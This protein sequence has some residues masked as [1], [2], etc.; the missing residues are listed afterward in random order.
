[1]K[2]ALSVFLALV[3]LIGLLVLPASAASAK[4]V[5]TYL[6]NIAK[7]GSYDDAEHAWY[8]GFEIGSNSEGTFFYVVSYMEK[9]K[10]VHNSIVFFASSSEYL[11]YEVT[12]KISSNPS[13]SYNAYVEVYDKGSSAAD[14]N[15]VVVL[16]AN[17]SGGAYSSFK[18]FSGESA[19]K[20]AMLELLNAFLPGVLEYTRAVINEQD[21]TLATLGMTGYKKCDWV[22]AFDKGKVTKTPTCGDPGTKT[23]TCRVCGTTQD[24]SIPATGEHQWKKED[25]PSISTPPT[26][27]EDGT[28]WYVC[29]VCV[30]TKS[31]VVPALGHDWRQDQEKTMEPSCTEEGKLAE[32][33]AR[34]GEI[35][36]SAL[37]ALGHDWKYTKTLTPTVD[38]E[39]GTALY[40]CQRCQQTK[41]DKLCAGLIFTDMPAEGN[42]AH[43][44]IDWAYFKGITSGKTPTT[45]APKA[46]VTRAE[47]VT[48]LWTAMGK[49]EPTLTENPFKDVKEGK[50]YYKPVLWAYEHNITG[51]KTENTFGWRDECSRAQI[52]TFLWSAAGKPEP[53]LTENPF[54]DVSEDKYYYKAVLWAYENS[55]TGGVTETSFGPSKTCTRAQTVTFLYKAYELLTAEP[56]PSVVLD[57]RWSQF[58]GEGMDRSDLLPGD[59]DILRVTVR[60]DEEPVLST[61]NPE[62]VELI[63]QSKNEGL[64]EENGEKVYEW[65]VVIVGSGTATISCAIGGETDRSLTILSSAD[66]S[67]VSAEWIIGE[68]TSTADPITLPVEPQTA[69]FVVMRY[70]VL[71]EGEDA[72]NP[73]SY[74]LPEIVTDVPELLN[75]RKSDNP[76]SVVGSHERGFL[77]LVSPQKA[78]SGTVSIRFRGELVRSLNV[79]V[80]EQ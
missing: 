45:F 70:P 13:P 47:V 8:D 35:R 64:E 48:F 36:E 57:W 79:I 19:Y 41:E 39:H 30:A 14:T 32:T 73:D 2:R 34:C 58:S 66:P 22:H 29:T 77:W 69:L 23:Y 7:E 80:P 68:E 72:P 16:P 3:L 43:N 9:T 25:D 71:P 18:T 63:P 40:T 49:P 67:F 55:I 59:M 6:M 37:A 28:T 61:D 74:E 51:G 38:S 11:S 5:H 76:V 17:Y 65:D 50:Y 10:Y 12:W 75:I 44:P 21:Y 33:C 62:V 4:D 53:T 78:G 31:E 54:T 42:W 20:T 15:G 56:E 24:E 52:V 60:G 46:K 1:M 26:C 27:T